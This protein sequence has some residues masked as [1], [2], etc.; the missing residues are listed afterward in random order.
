M[1]VT[2]GEPRNPQISDRSSTKPAEGPEETMLMFNCLCFPTKDNPTKV[3]SWGT[4]GTRQLYSRY[5]QA[6]YCRSIPGLSDHI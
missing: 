1:R 5:H 2:S 4:L 3:G 6:L